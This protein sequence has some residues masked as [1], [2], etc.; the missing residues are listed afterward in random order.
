MKTIDEFAD[1][2][3]KGSSIELAALLPTGIQQEIGHFNIFNFTDIKQNYDDNSMVSYQCRTFYKISFLSNHSLIEYPDQTIEISS[4]ALV[5]TSPKTPLKWTLDSVQTG[6]CCIFTA[7]FLHPTKSGLM[8]DEIPL[9]RSPEY[10]VFFPAEKDL[11]RIQ[12]IFGY[13]TEEITSD[14][15]YKYDL[16][17]AYTLE[18]IH[19]GQKLQSVTHLHPNHNAFARTTSLF[20]ELLERQF[21]IENP[22]QRIRL[23]TAGEF[24]VELSVHI[25][26][27]NKVLKETTGLTT[28]ELIAG[29]ILQEAK[30]LLL[31]TDWTISVIADSLGFSDFAHFAKFFKS[32]TGLSPKVFRVQSKQKD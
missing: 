3:S 6:S 19:I 25:N 4:P 1:G 29:R 32:E 30:L 12:T 16:L 22:Q 24:A 15:A 21:P 26:H 28:T 23:R 7:D 20:V 27:L 13:M 2:L 14:Y 17:R 8:L 11:A 31:R 5:F 10:P 9:Y 18:L